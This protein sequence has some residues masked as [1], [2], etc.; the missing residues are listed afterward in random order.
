MAV[1]EEEINRMAA[2][3]RLEID[4]RSEYV[5]KVQKML[6]YFEL[7]DSAG[8]DDEE[9]SVHEVPLDRLRP[10][11]HVPSK[12]DLSYAARNERGHIKAPRLG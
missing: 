11:E 12:H 7:L 5:E 8:V 4:D 9:I 2:M 3:M 6:D 1:T 10:D